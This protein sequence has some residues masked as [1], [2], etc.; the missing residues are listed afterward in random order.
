MSGLM[1]GTGK[2]AG[3]RPQEPRAAF[4]EPIE[5]RIL[6]DTGTVVINEIMYHPGMGE[7]GYA[8]YVAED[9][10]L[11]YIELYNKGA[12]AVSLKDWKLTQGVALTFPDVTIGAGAYLVVAADTTAFHTKYPSVDMAKVV[13]GWTGTLANSGEDVELED[14][15]GQ[16]MDFVS[17]T[18][19]GDWAQRRIGDVYPG[20]PSWWRGWDWTTGADAGG[21]SLEL[22]NPAVSNTYG[23][24]WTA[25][26][27]D[28]GTP[29]APNDVAAADIA[30]LILDV[31]Q[32]PIVP[33][34]TDP[35]TV[36][37]RIVDE[38]PTAKT[39]TLRW[40][41]DANPQTNPFASAPMY[42][43]GQHGDGLAGDGVYGAVL[44]QQPDRTI[45]EFY[46]Q[47]TDNGNRVRTWPAP[48]DDAGTQGANALYQVDDTVYAGDQPMYK[49]IIPAKEWADWTSLNSGGGRWSDAQMN[50]TFIA[51]D[52][53][54]PEIRYTCAI[55]NRGA[56]TRA[57]N[58]HNLQVNI[59]HDHPLNGRTRLEFNTQYTESQT[60][61]N[62]LF[63]MAGLP[64]HY[65]AP[66]QMRVNGNNLAN[67]GSPQFGSYYR[68]EPYGSEWADEHFSE[69]PQGNVYK[70]VWAFD[71]ISLSNG[72]ANLRY[73]GDDPALYRQVYSPTG[74]TSS[75]AAYTKQTNGAQDDW[76]DLI[77]LVKT[78][79]NTPDAQYA[80]AVSQVVN[81]DEWMG[82]LAATSLIGN[83]ET[84]LGTGIGDDYSLYRGVEDPR[85]QVL[86]H[87]MDTVLGEAGGC[88]LA[89][90]IWYATSMAALNRF[91]KFPDFA[92]RYYAAL[93]TLADTVFSADE[94]NPLLDRILG[95]WVNPATIQSMKDYAATRRTNV[96]AQIPLTISIASPETVQSG[97]PHTANATTSLTGKANAINT[98]SVKVNGVAAT[99]TQWSAS[100][101]AAGIALNPGIN[102]LVVQAFDS[103][104][105]EIDR[106]SIDVWYDKAGAG[107]TVAGGTISANTVWS[108]A[109]GP[110][111]VAGSLAIA[112]GATLTIQP[113][114]SVY[115]ASAA[116]FIVNGKLVAQG[117][118]YQRIRITR[119][120][121][122]TNAGAGI[123]FTNAHDPN[124]LA[125][126]DVEYSANR[127]NVVYLS[128]SQLLVDH[129]TFANNNT[130]TFD[131]WDP[132]FTL[133]HSVMGDVGAHYIMKVER[134]PVGGWFVVDSNL[135]GTCTGDNDIIHINGVSRKGG[136]VAQILNNLFTGGG[137]DIVD[138]NETDTHIE[139][140]F[141]TR[142]N[143]G[144]SAR[145]A[146]AAVTTGPGGSSDNLHSQHLTVVRNVF[147][148][149]DYGIL[150]KTGAYSQI[151]NNIF[152]ANRG[153][154]LFDE[155]WRSDSGPGR[156]IYIQ[157]SIF[158]NNQAEDDAAGSG[159]FVYVN[160]DAPDG[161]T[162]ITVNNSIVDSQFFQ[163]GTGNIDADPQF[164]DTSKT[165]ALSAGLSRFTTGFEGF[166]K[167]QS[168]LTD[169]GVPDFHLRA[170]S[171]ARGTG[172][173][174]VDMGPYT[175]TTASVSGAPT[176]PTFL[177]S[178]TLT[179]AGLDING[180][181]Y[182]LDGGAWS[183]ELAQIKQVTA[184]SR[185]GTT[186]TA[187][188][189]G[190]GYSNGDVIEIEGVDREAYNGL[191]TIFGVTTNTFSYTISA[192]VDI[193]DPTHL[194]IFC[195]KPQNI[196]LTGLANGSH[197]VDVIRKNSI[198]VWQDAAQP[199]SVTWTVNT[200]LAAHVRLSEVLVNNLT[201][202]NHAATFPDM[203]ELYNNGPGT[204]N[205]ADWSLSDN[206]TLP[207]KYVFP[208]GTTI[209]QDGYL[210]VYADDPDA[211]P[212]THVGFGLKADGDD[213]YL[214][215]SLALGGGLA[216]SVVF[217]IQLADR[218]IA[219]RA[220]G[221][222]GLATPT[223]GGLSS[224]V[225][226][227]A[228]NNSFIPMGDPAN[229]RINEWLTSETVVR[230]SDFIEL[231]NGDPAPVDMG[232]LYLTG[233]P[234]ALPYNANLHQKNPALPAPYVIPPLS[235]I[236]GGV[237]QGGLKIGAYTVFTADGDTT[238]GADHTDFTLSPFQGMI[239]LFDRNL[240]KIDT[241]WFGPQKLDTSQG[242]LPLASQVYA[243]A[244]I[245]TPGI[246]NPGVIY[247][248]TGSTTTTPL[249]T[250]MT[251]NW[252]YLA[253]ATDP[254]L[255]TAWYQ[256]TYA[257]DST[258]PS[259][260]GLLYYESNTAVTP[261]NTLL[262]VNGASSMY[263]TYY[264]RTHFTFSGNPNDVT[265]L[266]LKTLVDDGAVLYLNGV[267]LYRVRMATGA[268][269]Y[270]TLTENGAQPPGGDATTVE[271]W[272]V[273]MTPALKAALK[274]GD[275]VLSSEVHQSAT[276]SSDIVWGCTLD[277]NITTG[278]S[279]IVREVDIPANITALMNNLR[280]SEVMYNPP[281]GSGYEYIELKNTSTTTTLDLT[282]VR[283]TDAVD[284]I[285][286]T[287]TLAPG[288]YVLVAAD[289][290]KFQSRYGAGL[291]VAG[292][293]T[294]KLS[295]N[296]ELV[297]VKLPAPYET[298]LTRFTYAPD[299]YPPTNGGGRSLVIIN[300]TAAAS[301][302]DS[303]SSWRA[304]LGPAGSPGADEPA[305]P[306]GT[307]VFNEVL[308]HSDI[309]PVGDWIELKN[310]TSGA[311]DIGGWYLSDD[312]ANLTKY[313]IA[314]NTVI[315]AGDY[316]VLTENANFGDFFQLSELGET[317]Y[318]S[319]RLPDGSVGPYREIVDFGAT[320][321]EFSI[322]RYTTSRGDVQFVLL[323]RPTMGYVNS[324]PKV[325]P[326]VINELM[327]H[328]VAGGD[329]FVELAN[330]SSADVPLYNPLH[331]DLTWQFT[332]GIQYTFPTG[333]TL[334]SGALLLVVPI[335]PAAF[336]AKY[337]IPASVQIFGPYI[338]SLNNAG[339]TVTV[340]KP[341]DPEP[342]P[343]NRVPWQYVDS[344][345]YDN[346]FP[347]PTAPDGHGPSLERLAADLY[348]ND[349]ANWVAGPVGGSP[350]APNSG[351]PPR[352]T[353]IEVNGR[354]RG[355]A[356]IDPTL[357]GL[358]TVRVTLSV[359]VT[360]S[361]GDVAAATVTFDGNSET[362]TGTLTPAVSVSGNVLTLTLPAPVTNSWVKVTLKDSGTFVSA[363][364]GRRLDGEPRPGGSGRT[365][366]FDGSLDLPSG[367][368]IEGGDAVFYVGNLAGDFAGDGVI[369]EPDVSG[370]LDRFTAGDTDADFG[371][372]GF[373]PSAPD[374]QVTPWDIDGFISLY[375]A[376]SGQGRHLAALPNPGPQS[377]GD[378]GPLAGESAPVAVPLMAAAPAPTDAATP[379]AAGAAEPVTIATEA[380]LAAEVDL[381]AQAPAAGV[382]TLPGEGL[383]LLVTSPGP[384]PL[385]FASDVPASAADPVLQDDGGVDLLALA[386]VS[387]PLGA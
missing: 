211:T 365:Y 387:L 19:E 370:F 259:G 202:V 33:K 27:V 347:W 34:S 354:P 364:D 276:T 266:T 242:R 269:T 292:Q 129:C 323:D 134:M 101:S 168:Y 100:W 107:T 58:P 218:S 299:W 303:R 226:V 297:V 350:G 42:D 124:V 150:S 305:V 302:W 334:E 106:S 363:A 348:G 37:A 374:G 97:Y 70:G 149:N 351:S 115:L 319:S 255:G 335:D 237:V 86:T 95:G 145:S 17:Y 283:L 240:G 289:L 378:P 383:G 204:I 35:V 235:F 261:R 268:V 132:Q 48:T 208:A 308:A 83:G 28:G 120:P 380:S 74:P 274:N 275:N 8:G 369:S 175:S 77:N 119:Q 116:G 7:A 26:L 359:P 287:K 361:L 30:P 92:P 368:G 373:G 307:V 6:L 316:V 222:W 147:Y 43:D 216:D 176:S 118:D 213:L 330:I 358:Q 156:Q 182:R 144:N 46:V 81:V 138:D 199:T 153:A 72:G 60:V 90:P 336:R 54:A 127:G 79:N 21:K 84:T 234:V 360:L 179:V 309:S 12:A 185:S 219:R 288:Q 271:T 192:A 207:R 280:V 366:L 278:G 209:P 282:G 258:W 256:Y 188:V 143:I 80:Q 11:E 249:I 270:T 160:N 98:R 159:T 322:G 59:P 14:S 263:K 262:P 281:G 187:T 342:P 228:A 250:S 110:Y 36:T 372:A 197:T 163:Y 203:I 355:P 140:N 217:G 341:E 178:A 180:Y 126:A 244:A 96:L 55:R 324:G 225:N 111:T 64:A 220:D 215:K 108:P 155:P 238:A 130:Q 69:D 371:G 315:Q 231:Y 337:G 85:F 349:P 385:A 141:F 267:E 170:T 18:N 24:N 233:N 264:F 260:P 169:F 31:K 212:G 236:D 57:S 88:D 93:K 301:T 196:Q 47:A 304:S 87:D 245:P 20:Q 194:D 78:L 125:Y 151:Y 377:A 252:K 243:F 152:V 295:D 313:R 232:G 193:T 201:A 332:D 10:R 49:L 146:S 76:T 198:G 191:F 9:T 253:S 162:Q 311:I 1:D 5:P 67:A 103:G 16:R 294:G 339:E 135:F 61:G 51:L 343:D 190:H 52:G 189:A 273:T 386:E 376:A 362:V 45:I 381:L 356:G 382:P 38:L 200:A 318:L 165:F 113:G 148:A 53:T 142:A 317:L 3:E 306:Q 128:N 298:A 56:G 68:L 314:D 157:S 39:V 353:R 174:G 172:F 224:G 71:G 104:G 158:W 284:F 290:L 206:D 82:Y 285:F 352:V 239:G 223:F 15:L 161:H 99:W 66:V 183:T 340:L 44:A 346:A 248:S 300:P 375:D 164:V 246:E 345:T 327:Y 123:Q 272:T 166:D 321:R 312:G 75:A 357:S 293:F 247:G 102:R 221:T 227:G 333:V 265:T 105:I 121:G 205:L 133:S 186:V 181:K 89:R 22:I 73:L 167:A 184:I 331:P 32:T 344:V 122:T 109:S 325:G 137:D 286:P 173:N 112:A 379:P 251:Q 230:G 154:I 254:A 310:T 91:M 65:G 171:P 63:A 29:G 40:R 117:S 62:A 241:V 177:T 2:G 384:A 328:P 296:G 229:L 367:N 279:I 291:N 326:V 139:G 277:A 214:Y 41:I 4:F 338:G 50:G 136:P 13:G 257:A 195:R 131:I 329:G 210:V 114:T 23:Q 320:E 25:S 94:L